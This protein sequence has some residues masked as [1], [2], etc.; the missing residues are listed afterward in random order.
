MASSLPSVEDEIARLRGLDL[1]GLQARWHS[2]TGKRAPA[3]LP[4]HLLLRIL[5]YRL[6]AERFGDLDPA[7]A[8]ALDRLSKQGGSGDIPLP[9]AS[10]IAPGTLLVREWERTL[11]RV[12]V[13]ETG[14]A[15]NGSTYQSLSQVARAITGTRWNGPRF[16]GLREARR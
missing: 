16:F 8:R 1:S 14:F 6:Q 15:W 9:D 12:M 2:V 5:A 4:K 13:L 10:R 7:T 3:H 11:H